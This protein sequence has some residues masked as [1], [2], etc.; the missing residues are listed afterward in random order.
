MGI[1]TRLSTGWI[2]PCDFSFPCLVNVKLSANEETDGIRCQGDYRHYS[3]FATLH[4]ALLRLLA[5]KAENGE[6]SPF[7][8]VSQ[9]MSHTL[10]PLELTVD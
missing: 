1:L 2:R 6:R 8:M 7:A 5:R 3:P 9:S 10:W 4:L